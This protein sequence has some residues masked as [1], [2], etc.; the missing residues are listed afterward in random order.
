MIGLK[1]QPVRIDNKDESLTPEDFDDEAIA[2]LLDA[3]GADMEQFLPF[4]IRRG[5]DS[6]N[7]SE[8]RYD[9]DLL[10]SPPERS[11]ETIIQDTKNDLLDHEVDWK[12]VLEQVQEQRQRQLWSDFPESP[13]Q[14]G[15]SEA[16]GKVDSQR[17]TVTLQHDA[18]PASVASLDPLKTFF[19]IS[20]MLD[21]TRNIF[22][23]QPGTEFELFARVTHSCRENYVRRQYFQIS[24]L[25]KD[26]PP[27]L[28]GIFLDWKTDEAADFAAQ[29]FLYRRETGLKCRCRAKLH[30]EEL[31][32]GWSLLIV[33]IGPTSWEAIDEA[34]THLGRNDLDVSVQI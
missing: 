2:A 28:S 9:T 6:I 30:P 25:F 19:H 1:S 31:G 27:F 29:S 26:G 21:A 33:S 15:T 32:I 20:E 8:G 3:Q 18:Q 4:S 17:D 24:D 5:C 16:G 22:Q 7:Q 34:L 14:S 10:Y 12:P 11:S 23:D 13:R